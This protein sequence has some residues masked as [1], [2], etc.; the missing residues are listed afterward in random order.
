[1][2]HN[3]YKKDDLWWVYCR[4]TKGSFCTTV[5]IKGK[6]KDQTCPC[7]GAVIHSK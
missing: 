4:D 7:C 2:T 5:W 6:I 3:F 1:M